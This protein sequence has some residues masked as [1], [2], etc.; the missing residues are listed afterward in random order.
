MKKL[1]QAGGEVNEQTSLGSTPLLVASMNGHVEVVNILIQAGAEVNTQVK[2][3]IFKGWTPLHLASL[4]G[5]VEVITALLAGGAD[6]TLKDDCGK[7][8]YD[9]AYNQD[10]KNAL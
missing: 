6:K 2:E 1:I 8:P 5:H 7:T 10:C 4:N 9:V 3:G